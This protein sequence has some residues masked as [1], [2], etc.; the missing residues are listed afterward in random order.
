MN[1][2][3]LNRSESLSDLN[4]NRSL[5]TNAI[6][7]IYNRISVDLVSSLNKWNNHHRLA[8]SVAEPVEW[9]EEEEADRSM[10]MIENYEDEE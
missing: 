2:N 8:R 1:E 3:L 5:Y 4:I 7:T 6:T 9:D 10:R